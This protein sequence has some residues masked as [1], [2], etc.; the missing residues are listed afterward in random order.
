MGAA[1]PYADVDVNDEVGAFCDP[2]EQPQPFDEPPLLVVPEHPQ[3]QE[4]CVV[5]AHF[6]QQALDLSGTTPREAF[7]S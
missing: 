4:V 3:P 7:S 6:E 1:A 5:V 2:L